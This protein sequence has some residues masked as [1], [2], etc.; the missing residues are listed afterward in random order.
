MHTSY[1]NTNIVSYLLQYYFCLLNFVCPL[2]GCHFFNGVNGVE[3]GLLTC[4]QVVLLLFLFKRRR[5]GKLRTP[6]R[7]LIGD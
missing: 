5:K 6:D 3:N 2:L 4:D 1:T 7:R